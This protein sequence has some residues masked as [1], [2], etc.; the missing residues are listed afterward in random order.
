VPNIPSTVRVANTTTVAGTGRS[1][2]VRLADSNHDPLSVAIGPH[3][4]TVGD[5]DGDGGVAHATVAVLVR[6]R[7]TPV[8]TRRLVPSGTR[9]AWRGVPTTRARD[10]VTVNG[11]R[12][13]VT[14][15]LA[16][17]V[18]TPFGPRAPRDGHRARR[19]EIWVGR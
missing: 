15:A 3:P 12:A 1:L 10:L 7:A 17:T 6:P 16:C 5:G 11:H 8:A 19:V 13:C 18:A 14:S 2:V 9:I 4:V